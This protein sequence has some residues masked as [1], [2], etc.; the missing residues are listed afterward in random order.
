MS[1]RVVADECAAYYHPPQADSRAS[2]LRVKA[3]G[4]R[5][6]AKSR[7]DVA[8]RGRGDGR[9]SDAFLGVAHSPRFRVIFYP[10]LLPFAF[11]LRAQHVV[12]PLRVRCM[13]PGAISVRAGVS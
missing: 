1:F 2:T 10:P 4:K 9:D 11:C 7:N 6:K 13:H 3:K 12:F 8:T 5:Q